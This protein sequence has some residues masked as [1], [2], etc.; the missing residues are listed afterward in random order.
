M[1]AHAYLPSS[2]SFVGP[3]LLLLLLLLF[4][5]PSYASI[6]MSTDAKNHVQPVLTI[7]FHAFIDANKS[8]RVTKTLFWFINKIRDKKIT[9]ITQQPIIMIL[10]FDV[11]V[12]YI[13]L[14]LVLIRH[15]SM[16]VFFIFFFQKKIS[17]RSIDSTN[18]HNEPSYAFLCCWRF[19]VFGAK[20][21]LAA[22]KL[23]H[24]TPEKGPTQF[25]FHGKYF[26]CDFH[27]QTIIKMQY[28]SELFMRCIRKH[29]FKGGKSNL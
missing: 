5:F 25:I 13:F 2:F 20:S 21:A 10:C 18:F 15:R 17:V 9:T 23:M 27:R 24:F 4:L 11:N 29:I 6:I 7:H 22:Q 8:D 26:P 19:I 12:L 28:S 3:G 14:L 1:S 16:K